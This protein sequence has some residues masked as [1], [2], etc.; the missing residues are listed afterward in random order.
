[1]AGSSQIYGFYLESD[2]MPGLRWEWADKIELANVK[3]AGWYSDPEGIAELIRGVVFRLPKGRG[4]MPGWSMGEGCASCLE[5]VVYES[6]I[7]CAYAADELARIAAEKEREN[8]RYCPECA[9]QYDINCQGQLRCSVC[10]G[11]C[12]CCSDGD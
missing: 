1:M 11:P 5:R 9:E 10:D 2:G 12:L 6:R 7:M 4:F 3:H 8:S